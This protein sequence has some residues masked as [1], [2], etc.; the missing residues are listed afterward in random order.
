MSDVIEFDSL[1]GTHIKSACKDAADLANKSGKP[2]HFKFNGTDVTAQ[3]GE[4]AEILVSR[5]DADY[6]AARKAWL[7]SPEYAEREAKRAEEEKKAREAHMTESASTEQEMRNAK[8]PWPITKEQLMEY[9]ESL[10]NRQHDYGTCVYAMSMA[11]TAAF[12]YISNQLGASGFQASC[13]DLDI[14][15]RT[16]NIDGPFMIV[17][18]EDALYPQYDLYRNLSESLEKW[19]PWLKEKS[20]QKISE[21]PDAHPEVI[22]HWKKLANGGE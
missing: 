11:A 21:N 10:V 18:G 17:K 5:W 20:C 4:S 22:A 16:R 3:P 9:I 6:E 7:E 15:R 14:V 12:Y 8:V 1:P 13:A 2:V 19:K